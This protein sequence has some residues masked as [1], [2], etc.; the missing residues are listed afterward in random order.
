V[1]TNIIL[2]QIRK[3]IRHFHWLLMGWAGLMVLQL[4]AGTMD[5]WINNYLVYKVVSMVFIPL[6]PLMQTIFLAIFV[7]LLIQDEPLVGSTAFWFTRPISRLE[8][9][10][11]KALFMCVFFLFPIL[12]VELLLL[13]CHGAALG[14]IILA[15][16][17]IILGQFSIIVSCWIL[18][19]VTSRFAFFVLAGIGAL[20][21][22]VIISSI[23][24]MLKLVAFKTFDIEDIALYQCAGV[25]LSLL[26]AVAGIGIIIHQYLTRKTRYSVVF[27]LILLISIPA[28]TYGWKWDFLKSKIAPVDKAIVNPDNV[29]IQADSN[30]YASDDYSSQLF[31]NRK[32][33]K[34]ISRGLKITGLPQGV[35][36]NL[37][38]LR[39]IKLK[40]D[41]SDIPG[42]A[43]SL[44][45][46]STY[47]LLENKDK[48][49][50]IEQTIGTPLVNKDNYGNAFTKLLQINNDE[51]LKYLSASGTYSAEAVLAAYRY[52]KAAELPLKKGARYDKGSE[53]IVINDIL[54][55]TGGCNIILR[56]IEVSLLFDGK[57]DVVSPY[58]LS[59][60]TVYVLVNRKRGEAFLPDRNRMQ[61]GRIFQS[62]SKRLQANMDEI[63]FS[64]IKENR[65]LP[66][67]NDAW[68][69]DAALVILKTVQLGEFSRPINIENFSL[70]S[71]TRQSYGNKKKG[72]VTNDLAKIKLPENPTRDQVKT[73]V[74]DILN[75]SDSQNS[76]SDKD[77]QV[78]MLAKIGEDNLELLLVEGDTHDES[79]RSCYIQETAKLLARPKHKE[80]ILKW[81]EK[82]PALVT[83][84][85]REGWQ[86]DARETLSKGLQERSRENKPSYE[87][88]QA[89]ASFNDPSTYEDL[90]QYFAVTWWNKDR[91]YQIIKKLP[92]FNLTNAVQNAWHNSKYGGIYQLCDMIPIAME[93]GCLDALEMGVKVIT[94]KVDDTHA[95]R[96]DKCRKD[97]EKF[98]D[99]KGSPA[100]IEKWF[101]ENKAKLTFDS[102]LKKFVVKQ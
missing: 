56:N 96:I 100:D 49:D 48:L 6:A 8:L 90:A 62:H 23:V 52:D 31:G 54:R 22:N 37:N 12:L 2:L 65:S 72:N 29:G 26:I 88:F 30:T 38:K 42:L 35:A 84:V 95:S 45:S 32:Q 51:Y 98:T 44:S 85:Q 80:L 89:V 59:V 55:E 73:Y 34:I 86:N 71:G 47:E 60:D 83:I 46:H 92:G 57:N 78:S 28:I 5:L 67:I 36:V 10:S 41:N 70:A 7:C 20:A 76:F 82:Y 19:A 17:E 53:H 102:Q 99:A 87:W 101:N 63:I 9:A 1:N 81:L 24:S 16:P 58:L 15:V 77:P 3:D 64:C 4:A 11:A 25:V 61:I 14:H 50:A 18:A 13:T 93:N 94:G 39:A 91:C 74:R 97:I 40:I 66:E 75:V 27:A 21:F 33:R 79:V 43:S 68:L 69:A